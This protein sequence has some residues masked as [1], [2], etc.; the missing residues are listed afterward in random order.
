LQNLRDCRIEIQS[1]ASNLQLLGLENCIILAAPVATSVWGENCRNLILFAACQQLRLH[2]SE[3]CRLY[4]FTTS[5]PIIEDSKGIFV[6]PYSLNIAEDLW[7]KSGLDRNSP[8]FFSDVQDFNWL[9]QSAHSP[10]WQ[11]LAENEGQS[12]QF[13]L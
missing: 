9:S 6:A 1:P 11:I 10:N 2:K 13:M 8:K 5:K 12:Y 7:E 4:L 3:N